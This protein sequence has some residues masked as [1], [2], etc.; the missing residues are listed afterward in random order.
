QAIIPTTTGTATPGRHIMSISALVSSPIL[1]GAIPK[2]PAV[3][4]EPEETTSD[5]NVGGRSAGWEVMRPKQRESNRPRP[6]EGCRY[7]R[8]KCDRILPVC[9][10]CALRGIRCH[11]GNEEEGADPTPEM[12]AEAKQR[13]KQ[14]ALRNGGGHADE[15]SLQLQTVQR[16]AGHSGGGGIAQFG[17]SRVANAPR[18]V[19]FAG[20]QQGPQQHHPAWATEMQYQRERYE[21][22]RRQHMTQPTHQFA[23]SPTRALH[24]FNSSR[25]ASPISAEQPQQR[26][27]QPYSFSSQTNHGS[28]SELREHPSLTPHAYRTTEH[29]LLQQHHHHASSP[30]PAMLMDT[31]VSYFDQGY[32]LSTTRS[33]AIAPAREV[34]TAGFELIRRDAMQNNN[35]P[36]A[37]A[38]L[39]YG[40]PLTTSTRHMQP[41]PT[42]SLGTDSEMGFSNP[43]PP[44]KTPRTATYT[45][46]MSSE[47]VAPKT[48]R[49]T[50]YLPYSERK[51]SYTR[52][53][54]TASKT[55]PLTSY[56]LSDAEGPTTRTTYRHCSEPMAPKTPRMKTHTPF[57]FSEPTEHNTSRMATYTH[58]SEPL[59][60]PKT[61]RTTAYMSYFAEFPASQ[62]LHASALSTSHERNASGFQSQPSYPRIQPYSHSQEGRL[63]SSEIYYEPR[64]VM[65]PRSRAFESLERTSP[66]SCHPLLVPPP[67]QQRI[68]QLDDMYYRQSLQD[69]V[70]RLNWEAARRAG[71]Q[72]FSPLIGERR[73]C[74]VRDGLGVGN[75][76][77]APLERS[78]M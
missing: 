10:C 33:T 32:D 57:L 72:S 71:V 77:L 19:N 8:K 39:S 74:V 9:T 61:P 47:Q 75:V 14:T 66:T 64:I 21:R 78:W 76:N 13:R 26:R 11:Y 42:S 50:T 28:T 73:V 12:V 27:Y 68:Q 69:H 40:P 15:F 60:A 31:P 17:G 67:Q 36:L 34:P 29:P 59:A 35:N 16:N 43:P 56:T 54:P 70:D 44:P 24:V 1:D 2:A 58:Y 48:P 52:D 18:P 49:M 45:S 5:G 20:P 65:V 4:K 37:L 30:A 22:E 25:H 51:T 55:P 23:R 62:T 7:Q 46:F 53:Y 38:Q 63:E 41:T 6:C 3:K